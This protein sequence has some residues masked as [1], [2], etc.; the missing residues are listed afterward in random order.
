LIT[1][2]DG[3]AAVLEMATKLL[4]AGALALEL[5]VLLGVGACAFGLTV[6]LG[7][8]TGLLDRTT[9]IVEL[10]GGMNGVTVGSLVDTLVDVASAAIEAKIS[11][12]RDA[13]YETAL[14]DLAAAESLGVAPCVV[15]TVTVTMAGDAVTVFTPWLTVT[16]TKPL[17][18][19][20]DF[21]E[22]AAECDGAGLA[23]APPAP[24]ESGPEV[25][26]GTADPP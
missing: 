8:G 3:A 18:F 21:R 11:D 10:T 22:D 23:A 4:E 7:L 26:R 5:A 9:G 6:L 14:A 20:F 13:R 15:V 25:G 16:V 12:D 1:V 2:L 24:G 17:W 19:E